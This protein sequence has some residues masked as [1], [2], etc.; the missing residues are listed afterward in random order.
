MLD[1]P[2][3]GTDQGGHGYIEKDTVVNRRSRQFDLRSQFCF[4]RDENINR[5]THAK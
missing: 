4:R 5:S 1:I 2:A 3:G